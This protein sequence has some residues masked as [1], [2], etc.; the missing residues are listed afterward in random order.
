MPNNVIRPTN[1]Y[2]KYCHTADIEFQFF[3]TAPLI[4]LGILKLF[5]NIYAISFKK[6]HEEAV[7]MVN[8][9]FRI[10]L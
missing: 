10:N 4:L 9:D 2:K 1:I 3:F 5:N 7:L 6:F 8:K